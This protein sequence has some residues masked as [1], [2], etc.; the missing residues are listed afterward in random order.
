MPD[1]T[2]CKQMILVTRALPAMPPKCGTKSTYENLKCHAWTEC[3]W[4][5]TLNQQNTQYYFLDIYITISH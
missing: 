4:L 1:V 3:S 5:T 2:Q